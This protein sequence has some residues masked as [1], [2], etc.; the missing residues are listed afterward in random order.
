[1]DLI[2]CLKSCIISIVYLPLWSIV[3]FLLAGVSVT[4]SRKLLKGVFVKMKITG[5]NLMMLMV[6]SGLAVN[7][8][9]CGICIRK[10]NRKLNYV[11]K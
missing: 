4:L 3:A 7:A 8:G 2:V 9:I 11:L 10:L 6:T 5:G 1:M